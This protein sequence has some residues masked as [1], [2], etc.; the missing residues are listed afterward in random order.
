MIAEPGGTPDRDAELAD[1]ATQAV[2]TAARDH[3]LNPHAFAEELAQGEIGLLMS[4]LSAASPHVADLDL[5]T[6]INALL[7]RL[8]AWTRAE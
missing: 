7:H 4:Y 1:L 6:R 3:G 2:A 5:R 8:T